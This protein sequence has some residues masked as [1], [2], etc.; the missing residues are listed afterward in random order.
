M[1]NC[2]RVMHNL[3]GVLIMECNSACRYAWNTAASVRRELHAFFHSSSIS[4][5]L[6]SEVNCSDRDV[7]KES[8]RYLF[9]AAITK[10]IGSPL[11]RGAAVRSAAFVSR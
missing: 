8:E 7:G 10:T 2:K 4:I 11:R 1:P 9:A 6:T 3:C 5:Q